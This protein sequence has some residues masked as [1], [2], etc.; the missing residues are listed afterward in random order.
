MKILLR[1]YMWER[2]LTLRQVE[3][4]TG[5]SKSTLSRILNNQI[6]PSMD[7]MERLASGLKVR[8]SNLYE[9]DFK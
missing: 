1:S 6:S 3:I 8:I 5:V 4:L 7:V 2:N 9:S